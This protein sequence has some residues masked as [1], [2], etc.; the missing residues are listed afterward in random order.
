MLR[1][2]YFNGKDIKT[3]KMPKSNERIELK[4]AM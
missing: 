4:F 3:H 2:K 1:Q